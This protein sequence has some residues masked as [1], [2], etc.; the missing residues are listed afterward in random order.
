MSI[1]DAQ[2]DRL[3]SRVTNDWHNGHMINARL[4]LY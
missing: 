2:A 4:L 3:T 1:D